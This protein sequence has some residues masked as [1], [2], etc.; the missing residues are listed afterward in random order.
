[1]GLADELER[2]AA[3]AAALA[4]GRRLTAVL[5]AE[6]AAGARRYLCAFEDDEGARAWAVLD[7]DGGIVRSRPDIRDAASIAALCEIAEEA[8]FPGDLDELRSQLVAL[9]LTEGP[10]G[11]GEAEDAA[12]ALQRV[13]GAPPQIATPDRLEAIGVAARRLERALDPTGTS[14]FTN[15]MRS[16]VE[17]ADALWRDVESAYLGPLQ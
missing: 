2:T 10:E 17:V 15:A 13:I 11:I 1:M 3:A 9:R 6:A 12:L 4:D 14:P 16:A 8:A 7:A 5:P